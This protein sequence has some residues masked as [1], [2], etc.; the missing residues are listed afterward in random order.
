MN[1]S[2]D[3]YRVFYYAAKYKS[4]SKAAAALY[5]NQPNVTRII[6]RLESELRCALFFRSAQ[7][8][9]LTPEGEKIF[10]HIAIA[11]E[12]IEAAE[13]EVSSDRSLQSG[14]LHIAASGLALRG[15]LLQVLAQYR[16]EYP[17]V[18]IYLTNHSTPQGLAAVQNGLADFAVVTEGSVI[19]DSLMK[20]QVGEIQDIPICGAAFAELTHETVSL[21]RLVDYPIVG[22]TEGTSSHDFYSR[23]FLSHDLPYNPDVEVET[24]DQVLPVVRSNLGIGFVPREMLFGEPERTG[25]FPI[26]LSEPI[27]PRSIYLFQRKNQPLSIAAKRLQQMLLEPPL[28][29]A[30]H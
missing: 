4:F 5:N 30:V 22:L 13:A 16:S 24:I 10:A 25:I 26:A 8:V 12:N 18:R 27:P 28:Q 20:K 19:P 1:I 14:I 6:R 17:R 2:Y 7:G 15:C 23:L 9:R 21:S 11:F 3:S 29:K